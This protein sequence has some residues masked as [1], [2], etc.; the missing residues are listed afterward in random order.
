M[1][2]ITHAQDTHDDI[3]G[4]LA[5]F[6]DLYNSIQKSQQWDVEE[7]IAAVLIKCRENLPLLRPDHPRLPRALFVIAAALILRFEALGEVADVDDAIIYLDES[8]AIPQSWQDESVHDEIV[9]V[10]AL[11]LTCLGKALML[12]FEHWKDVEDMAAA[13]EN[14]RT[15][16]VLVSSYNP[17]RQE[18]LVALRR[19]SVLKFKT[20]G[21][22]EDADEA[23]QWQREA[24][25]LSQTGSDKGE[26]KES[27][28]DSLNQ[29]G[30]LLMLR[31]RKIGQIV[32]L[33][34]ARESYGK[35]LV[36]LPDN[37][38]WRPRYLSDLAVSLH[39][40][41]EAKGQ[42]E[43]LNG[44]ISR[45]HEALACLSG[46]TVLL[47]ERK[48]RRSL[49]KNL[50]H[51]GDLLMDR[52]RELKLVVDLEG[53]TLSYGKAVAALPDNSQRRPQYLRALAMSLLKTFEKKGSGTVSLDEGEKHGLLAKNSNHLGDLLMLRY[54]KIALIADLEEATSNYEKALVYLPD[55]SE[56]RPQYLKDLAVSLR[57][58]FEAKGRVE[59]LNGAIDRVRQALAYLSTRDVAPDKGETPESLAQNLNHLGDLLVDRYRK[60]GLIV[61]LEEATSSY[62]EAIAVLTDNSGSRP[63]YLRDLAVSLQ[64]TFEAKGRVEDLNEA[65]GYVREAL[66]C[67]SDGNPPSEM[68]MSLG[69][70][71][72]LLEA[73]FSWTGEMQDFDEA[74]R[75]QYQAMELDP[76]KRYCTLD[77]LSSHLHALYSM[78]GDHSDL[79]R[80]LEFSRE[81]LELCPVHDPSSLLEI[82]RHIADC[83]DERF[84]WSD[85]A[86]DVEEALTIRREL[87]ALTKGKVGHHVDVAN[88]VHCLNT[89]WRRDAGKLDAFD[90]GL[91]Q[92]RDLLGTV[93][94]GSGRLD[95]L[96]DL[97]M[98]SCNRH[99]RLNTPEDLEESIAYFRELAALTPPGHIRH[100]KHL[101]TLSGALRCRFQ[102]FGRNEDIND[103]VDS[104]RKAIA[105]VRS[106]HRRGDL[107]VCLEALGLC[108]GIRSISLRQLDGIEAIAVWRELVSLSPPGNWTALV[109]LA[110]SILLSQQ[111]PGQSDG[112]EEA[113]TL[114]RKS[115]TLLPARHPD[116]LRSLGALASAALKRCKLGGSI[117]DLKEAL[118][119]CRENVAAYEGLPLEDDHFGIS[120]CLLGGHQG[121]RPFVITAHYT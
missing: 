32:D 14:Y 39:K 100:A 19:A 95:V 24:V 106:S 50:S 59:D 99:M 101:S 28:A 105:I 74:V 29:L 48:I 120:I 98:Y 78:T 15:A 77:N 67:P 44:A 51:L 111:Q 115:L 26:T 113:I 119:I 23:I 79:K 102:L 62:G 73:R 80:A 38:E 118:E 65:I 89:Q 69:Y 8:L 34:E 116:Q 107:L 54:R 47:D 45:V 61:D 52:Y 117:E 75:C 86:E 82:K 35:A 66:A 22:K 110:F 85:R 58:T 1:A 4:L 92:L 87:V 33:E 16:L 2:T 93:G 94:H 56:S 7:G 31:Y 20:Y 103:A 76:T 6:R 21:R 55:D 104:A 90:E 64:E 91:K 17:V 63:H 10:A 11:S 84:V 30:D 37:S 83:L 46:G 97:G 5:I 3:P 9:Y 121:K 71:G 25:S 27:L 68:C 72:N 96:Y 81:A 40:T 49:A 88:F 13:I 18:C 36:L 42:I 109:N 12:R 70:L 57:K 114:L 43:D 41:F 108:L 60:V 112:I 53:A